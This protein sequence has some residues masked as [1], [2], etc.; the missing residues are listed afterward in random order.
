[1]SLS[2]LFGKL[3]PKKLHAIETLVT[4]G[5][6]PVFIPLLRLYQ[7]PPKQR[8]KL[9]A[10]DFSTYSVGTGLFFLTG[11]GVH[12]LL[13]KTALIPHQPT[14]RLLSFM[15]AITA[16]VLYAGIGAVKLS[17]RINS[18]KDHVPQEMPH[19]V[20]ISPASSFL[21]PPSQP[22]NNRFAQYGQQPVTPSPYYPQ[23]TGGRFAH[24][25]PCRF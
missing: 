11:L 19:S 14:R 3:T 16:N 24:Y 22:F 25:Q 20:E 8:W 10:R 15:A 23:Y 2:K 13:S 1:M 21:P 5:A 9:F 12:R 6:P 4:W 7:D 18:S 17:E